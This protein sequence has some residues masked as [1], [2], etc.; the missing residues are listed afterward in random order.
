[1]N[2]RAALAESARTSTGCATSGGWV[3]VGL[4]ECD[5]VQRCVEL[6]VT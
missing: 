6:A 3:P 1:M 4:G 5:A 2:A